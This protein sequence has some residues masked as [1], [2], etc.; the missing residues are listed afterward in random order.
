MAKNKKN[1]V[2]E[3]TKTENSNIFLGLLEILVKKPVTVK[4]GDFSIK[5]GNKPNKF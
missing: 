1:N 3:N 4:K 2:T 5:F